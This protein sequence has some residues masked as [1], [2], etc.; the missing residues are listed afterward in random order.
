V[1]RRQFSLRWTGCSGSRAPL[2]ARR[3]GTGVGRPEQGWPGA[4]RPNGWGG[5]YERRGRWR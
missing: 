3:E 4:D 5:P 1:W 2:P